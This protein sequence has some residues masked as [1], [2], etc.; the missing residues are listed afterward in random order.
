MEQRLIN[1]LM[2]L[3][4]KTGG[5]C[6]VKDLIR[7]VDENGNPKIWTD[8]ELNRAM[9]YVTWQVENFGT[10]EAR[11]IVESLIQ[12]YNVRT[13]DLTTEKDKSLTEA[14]GVQGLQ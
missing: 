8:S 2:K 6:L 10:A 3:I 11:A 5:G 12:K 13:E 14:P 7:H 4:S 1:A 9:E